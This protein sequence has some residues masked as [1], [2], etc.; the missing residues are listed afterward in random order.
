M[1]DKVKY[2]LYSVFD[3]G[4]TFGGTVAVIIYNYV[5]AENTL[6]FKISF[7]GIVLIVALL[8]TAKAAFE[9]SYRRKYDSLLQQLAEATREEDK[10]A[11][12]AEINKHKTKNYVYQ[13]L[14]ILLPFVILYA[15][16][17]LGAVSLNQLKGCIG[18]ILLSLS[19]GSVF[20]VVK[21]PV[22]ERLSLAKI[23]KK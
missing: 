19:A 22:A 10:S 3:F 16:C 8:L 2:I 15:V 14:M 18:I 4:F 7:T 1:S 12:S 23:I 6:G 20:H 17:W 5:S 13:R 21:K 11:L 9:K